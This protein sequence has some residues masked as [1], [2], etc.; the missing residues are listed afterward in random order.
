MTG[1]H[2]P[3]RAPGNPADPNET[4]TWPRR[5]PQS[6]WLVV[7]TEVR[8]MNSDDPVRDERRR[9]ERRRQV[10]TTVNR[11]AADEMARA[12]SALGMVRAGHQRVKILAVGNR[13]RPTRTASASS[14]TPA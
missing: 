3:A 1:E 13:H 11:G 8:P 4:A 14:A 6:F 7:L 2:Y 5:T 9:P 10:I 12:L